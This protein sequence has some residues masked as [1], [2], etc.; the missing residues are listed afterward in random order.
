MN[1]RIFG[2]PW[3]GG[4]WHENA[5]LC[6]VGTVMK[7]EGVFEKGKNTPSDFYGASKR[8]LPA[9]FDCDPRLTAFNTSDRRSFIANQGKP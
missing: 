3:R 2:C 7:G 9:L 6:T 8:K 1:F 4:A 5:R